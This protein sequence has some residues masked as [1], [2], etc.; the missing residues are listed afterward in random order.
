MYHVKIA[1]DVPVGLYISVF[2]SSMSITSASEAIF[3]HLHSHSRT[4]HNPHVV[5]NAQN[6]PHTAIEVETPSKVAS[7]HRHRPVIA[8][9]AEIGPMT[10]MTK[11]EK[12]PKNAIREL[13]CGTRIE[14]RI[15]MTGT[16]IRSRATRNCFVKFCR[17]SRNNPFPSSTETGKA[18]VSKPSIVSK[19]MFN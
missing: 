13:N 6:V 15:D 4:S 9:F 5:Q 10:Q 18:V 3:L 16:R 14:T 12:E 2:N 17:P 11:A 8:I 1:C 7:Y 19:M